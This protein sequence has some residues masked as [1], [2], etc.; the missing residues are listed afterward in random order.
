VAYNAG[1]GA[2]IRARRRTRSDDF[3]EFCRRRAIPRETQN[4][5]PIILAMT[6]MAKN[7]RQYGLEDVIPD[8]PLEYNTIHVREATHLGLIADLLGRPLAEIRELNP[9]ILRDVA[10]AGYNV[11]V[12][13]GTGGFVMAALETVPPGRRASW[14][15][16]RLGQGETLT[17]I[18]RRYR[19]PEESIRLANGGDVG[20]LEEGDLMLIPVGY[21]GKEAS[22]GAEPRRRTRRSARP[23]PTAGVRLPQPRSAALAP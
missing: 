7:P 15:V 11:H 3:W 20:S 17:E 9:A 8:P 13:K 22:P 4:Y 5:V 1:P 19:I 12:P 10:P 23:T 6:I 21:P 18:A 14:R 2:V 16:H